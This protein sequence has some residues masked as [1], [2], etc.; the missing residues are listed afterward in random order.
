MDGFVERRWTSTRWTALYARD[1]AG[2]AGEARLPVVCL[3]GLTR[4]SKDFEEFAPIVAATGR[5]VIVPDV[6]GRGRSERDPQPE[7]TTCPKCTPATSSTCS[8]SSAFRA[9]SSSALRWAGSSRWD[10]RAASPAVAGCDAQRRRPGSRQG[11][12]RADS[13]PM[14]A[15]R[16]TIG[17]WDDAADYVRA[18]NGAAFPDNRGRGLGEASRAAHSPNEGGRPV[19]D[20]DPAIMQPAQQGPLQGDDLHR[21]V[22]VQAAGAE[23]SH[24][25]WSAASCPT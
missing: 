2:A 5:R 10:R 7:P 14:S 8:I 13:S 9:P 22:S 19:L 1:Y 21:L 4:N 11:R 15:R 12:H 6:R 18:I 3:H 25:C 17:S 24:S 16:S 23:T 20:Y